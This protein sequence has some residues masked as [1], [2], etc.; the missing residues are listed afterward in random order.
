M[1]QV[2]FEKRTRIRNKISYPEYCIY[3]ASGKKGLFHVLPIK[4]IFLSW[5][6]CEQDHYM[7]VHNFYQII[8]TKNGTGLL[9][10][11]KD[12]LGST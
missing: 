3:S 8:W 10:L 6:E 9:D 11:S 7:H 12:N 5:P 4:D 1:P 2:K